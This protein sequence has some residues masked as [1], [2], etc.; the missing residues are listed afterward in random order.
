MPYT[1]VMPQWKAGDLH[2][3]SKQGPK[4]KSQAQ[5]VAIMLD[6]KRKAK[7]GDE[8]YEAPSMKGLRRA[9]K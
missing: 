7:A 8:E 2:S 6:E 3:G 9:A 4:V 1:N 5:A